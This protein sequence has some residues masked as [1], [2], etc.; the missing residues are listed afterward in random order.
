MAFK[1]RDE[2]QRN[3]DARKRL[4]GVQKID[5]KRGKTINYGM[6]DTPLTYNEFQAELNAYAEAL[7]NY[8]QILMQADSLSNRLQVLENKISKMY[9]AILK[10]ASGKF[11]D[12]ADEIEMLGG[13]R[14]SDR[15]FRVRKKEEVK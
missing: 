2:S 15:K 7:R 14:A 5:E 1:K 6:D 4:T 10:S 9:T 13:T 11:G 12:D 8:N 3:I